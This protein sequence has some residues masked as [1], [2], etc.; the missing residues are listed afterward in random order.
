MT[1]DRTVFLHTYFPRK[2]VGPK[3]CDFCP[4]SLSFLMSTSQARVWSSLPIPLSFS[5]LTKKPSQNYAQSHLQT[6]YGS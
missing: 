1:P 4:L 2:S 3:D 5:E 6:S